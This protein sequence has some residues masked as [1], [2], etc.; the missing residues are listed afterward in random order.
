L[1]IGKR[2]EESEVQ[3]M[4]F[5]KADTQDRYQRELPLSGDLERGFVLSIDT[6]HIPQIRGRETRN[7]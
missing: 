1:A 4:I 3:R 6:A 7:F 5:E 2:L